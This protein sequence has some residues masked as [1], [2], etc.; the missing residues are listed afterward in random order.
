MYD[1]L[2]LIPLGIIIGIIT[3]LLP[4]IHINLIAALFLSFSLP[5]SP[6]A[7]AVLIIVIATTHILTEIIPTTYLGVPDDELFI[8]A[9]PAQQ[10]TKEG[11]ATEA[12]TSY[13]LGTLLGMILLLPLIPLFLLVL[14]PL[15]PLLIPL[16][17]YLLLLFSLYLILR[18]ENPLIA[19]VVFI[20]AGYLGL[21]TLH[22]PLKEPLLPLLKCFLRQP[23]EAL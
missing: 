7:S 13:H 3:G 2:F 18:A 14:P 20:L 6:E 17:P 1:P 10:L 5:F 21:I 8:I 15:Y 16:I 12:I 19:I 4:S 22:V 9:Q 23:S 11:R